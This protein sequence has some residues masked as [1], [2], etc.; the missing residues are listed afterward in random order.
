MNFTERT[1]S[2][3]TIYEGKILK[4]KVEEVSLPNGDISSREIIEFPN[5]VS[6]IAL[7][8]D[9]KVILVRQYRKPCEKELL[10][11]VAG[12]VDKGEDALNCAKRELSEETG[13][14]SEKWKKV[15][16]FYT[17]PGYSNE[18]M[19]MFIAFNVVKGKA[20]PDEDEFVEVVKIEL[21]KFLKEVEEGRIIDA[22]TVMAAFYLKTII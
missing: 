11:I 5:S 4:L 2:S 14:T 15:A 19:T 9:N 7:T 20:H 18:F 12:K 6:V 13:Y 17:T 16:S 10:E 22:K 3:N 21:K 8:E 1:L